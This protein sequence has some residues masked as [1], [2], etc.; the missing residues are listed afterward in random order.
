MR[1]KPWLVILG[2]ALFAAACGSSPAGGHPDGGGTTDGGSTDGG[3]TGGTDGGAGDGGTGPTQTQATQTIGFDGGTITL[4]GATVTFP[5]GALAADT[6]IT[7]THTLDA[8]PSGF[9]S[10]A[11][12]WQLGPAATAITRPVTVSLPLVGDAGTA[13]AYWSDPAGTGFERLGATVAG[14]QVRFGVV[15]LGSGFVATTDGHDT[16]TVYGLVATIHDTPSGGTPVATDLRSAMVAA[17]VPNA[18]HGLDLYPATGDLQGVIRATGVPPSPSYTLRYTLPPDNLTFSSHDAT[19]DLTT[20]T[21]VRPGL[22]TGANNTQLVA[23]VTGLAAWTQNLDGIG[24]MAPT[25]GITKLYSGTGPSTS[26]ATSCDATFNFKNQPL[27]TSS[28]TARLVQVHG[29]RGTNRYDYQM[30]STGTV[31]SVALASGSSTTTS[32]AM[33]ALGA[34]HAHSL[35]LSIDGTGLQAWFDTV[36]APSDPD[37]L[38]EWQGSVTIQADPM[39]SPFVAHPAMVWSASIGD[40]TP[41]LDFG[42]LSY[43]DPYPAGWHRRF[44]CSFTYTRA[45]YQPGTTPLFNYYTHVSYQGTLSLA[46]AGTA[47]IIPK[48]GAVANIRVN[49]QQTGAVL[50]SVGVTPQ[51]TWTPPTTGATPAYY[52]VSIATKDAPLNILAWLYTQDPEMRIPQGILAPGTYYSVTVDA[53]GGAGADPSH[54]RS[55]VG[56]ELYRSGVNFPPI[57]P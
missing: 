56:L 44:W 54:L 36:P 27:L 15:R 55:P 26:G 11:R 23:H 24:L 46:E 37:S 16:V 9:T 31:S 45:N 39:A 20:F 47:A 2:I 17:Y 21:E 38:H 43:E 13:A 6:Q 12:T 53:Y 57:Q 35:P 30:A 19:L 18:T 4:D 49:G 51:I 25:L 28:D 48:I 29:V 7:L 1:L 42:N 10:T 34:P 5:V 8:P 50:T 3:S 52:A 32:V 14:G 33:S 40:T 41:N 22:A